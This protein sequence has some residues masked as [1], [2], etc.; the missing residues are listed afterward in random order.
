MEFMDKNSASLGAINSLQMLK[1]N[2][3]IQTRPLSVQKRLLCQ[4]CLNLFV[5]KRAIPA[6]LFVYFR[7]VQPILA[8]RD[9]NLGL[10]SRRRGRQPL[11]YHHD[12]GPQ[13]FVF[14]NKK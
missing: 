12:D 13:L 2:D 10:L 3:W 14:S 11:D 6:L 5:L 7:S 4:L 9:S 1:F 8:Q